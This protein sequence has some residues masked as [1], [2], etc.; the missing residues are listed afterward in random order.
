MAGSSRGGTRGRFWNSFV[1]VG[2][3]STMLEL[4]KQACR[5]STRPLSQFDPHSEHKVLSA[6][7]AD[8]VVLPIRDVDWNDRG[9][10]DRVIVPG[11]WRLRPVEKGRP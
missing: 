5:P 1:M 4:I 8:L 2:R 10:T 9:N 7:S 6:V 3:A 11:F